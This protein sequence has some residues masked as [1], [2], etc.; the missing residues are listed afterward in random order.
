[1]TKIFAG[2][3]GLDISEEK[4]SYREL[5]EENT[6]LKERLKILETQLE[7]SKTA[8]IQLKEHA[9]HLTEQKLDSIEEMEKFLSGDT[10]EQSLYISPPSA[11]SAAAPARAPLLAAVSQGLLGIP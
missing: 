7:S 5:S 9:T 4:P 3:S 10:E 6:S 2:E 1:M 8:Y 11:P